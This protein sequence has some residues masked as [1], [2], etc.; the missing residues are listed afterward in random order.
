MIGEIG[1]NGGI[2][3]NGNGNIGIGIQHRHLLGI[4]MKRMIGTHK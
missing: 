4:G 3:D 1:E 2:G